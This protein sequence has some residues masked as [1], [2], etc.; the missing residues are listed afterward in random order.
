M[1]KLSFAIV[2]FL[3]IAG[4]CFA[5][6]HVEPV[7]QWDSEEIRGN[8]YHGFAFN[9]GWEVDFTVESQDGRYSL[10]EEDIAKAERLIQKR[11]AYVNRNHENQEGKCPIIDEHLNKYERQYVG[12]TDVYGYHIAWVN[13]IWDESVKSRLGK[14]VILTKGGCGHYWHIKVNLDTEK[15]YGLEVNEPGDVKYL[16]RLKKRPPRISR[17][18]KPANPMKIRKTGIIHSEAEKQF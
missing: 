7:E 14:D 1:R 2:S 10:T 5:Q 16:P 8:N 3:F 9:E 17:P 13:F 18:K 6:D 11:I 4:T 12:F 15:V